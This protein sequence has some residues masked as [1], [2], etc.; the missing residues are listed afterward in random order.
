MARKFLEALGCA[1]EEKPPKFTFQTFQDSKEKDRPWLSRIL[2]G[3]FGEV[4]NDLVRLN[5]EGA[6]IFVCVNRTDLAGRHANNVVG[7]RAI[8]VDS[9]SGDVKA[10]RV[11]PNI[12]VQTVQGQHAYWLIGLDDMQKDGF[13]AVQQGIAATLGTDPKIKDA[14]RVMRLPGFFH[15]KAQPKMVN[16]LKCDTS[17]LHSSQELI[18][19]LEIHVQNPSD[20]AKKTVDPEKLK[21]HQANKVQRCQRYMD[22]VKPAIEGSGGDFDTLVAAMVGGDFDLSDDEFWPILWDWNQRCSPPWCESDLRIK[23]VNAHRYRT[24]AYGH[25]LMED[26]KKVIRIHHGLPEQNAEEYWEHVMQAVEADIA[27]GNADESRHGDPRGSSDHM[28]PP[29]YAPPPPPP[30][31]G[32]GTSGGAGNGGGGRRPPR[33]NNQLL[34]TF[35]PSFGPEPADGPLSARGMGENMIRAHRIMQTLSGAI[36]IYDGTRWKEIN[37]DY[38][39]ALAITFDHFNF[40]TSKR[41]NETVQHVLARTAVSKVPWNSLA[42]SEVPLSDGVLNVL[43]NTMREH[44]WQDFLD[45][46]LPHKRDPRASCPLWISCLN[47]WFGEEKDK[48][49]ALQD[50]FGYICLA[51]TNEFKRALFLYGESNTGKSVAAAV[52]RELVGM[53]NIC[54]IRLEDMDEPKKRAPIK[55]KMLN[56][57]TEMSSWATISE[58]GFKMLVSTGEPVEIEKKYINSE[59]IIPYTKHMIATNNLPQITDQT[60]AVYNRL[61]IIQFTKVIPQRKMDPHLLNRLQDEMPGILAWAV[62]GARRLIEYNGEFTRVRSSETLIADY[63][64]TNNQVVMFMEHG[65]LISK[66]PEGRIRT[67]RFRELFNRFKGGKPVGARILITWAKRAGLEVPDK[68]IGG[69]RYVLGCRE[70]THAEQ[71]E[72]G[73]QVRMFNP[74]EKKHGA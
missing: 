47:D 5:R 52:A 3:T 8:F 25:K 32:S 58:G 19:E 51:G 44:R 6:G 36:Y 37:K 34:E 28:P 62:E 33:D 23:L 42:K 74:G 31:G 40:T 27:N 55:G 69:Y 54:Q 68:K 12:I 59:T 72:A 57:I 10:T 49:L 18:E 66:D 2:H 41:R 30:P 71:A 26:E 11:A 46:C 15:H 60:E 13:A 4:C 16:L 7:I 20:H 50:F 70:L 22:K 53:S 43:T 64:Q 63:K 21:D 1:D 39:K 35:R 61:L 29:S 14:A 65:G 17:T 9:D 48:K 45:T 24:N 38:L 56:L 67:S 73:G